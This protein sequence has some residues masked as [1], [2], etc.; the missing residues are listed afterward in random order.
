MSFYPNNDGNVTARPV[1]VN[2][3][4]VMT[5][6]YMWMT[7][8]LVIAAG[9]AYFTAS[10]IVN[11]DTSSLGRAAGYIPLV[12]MIVYLVMAFAMWPVVLRS[13]PAVG[14]LFYLV[15]TAVTGVM[16]SYIFFA[17]NVGTI[18]AAF[19][20]TAGTFGITSAY[21]YLTK[22]DLSGLGGILFMG[23]IGIILASIANIFIGGYGLYMLINYVAVLVFIGLAAYKTQWIKNYATS[24]AASGNPEMIQKVSIIGAFSL[25]ITFVNLFL[26]ILRIMGGG[27]GGR[28]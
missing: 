23:L 25:Y 8:G 15:F 13:S 20:V 5:Q 12:F 14:T 2:V 9:T 10:V 27:R 1:E 17:Y 18:G 19:M 21:G 7:L 24:A 16:L 11:L 3:A 28:R 22:R 4:S 26:T 6:V